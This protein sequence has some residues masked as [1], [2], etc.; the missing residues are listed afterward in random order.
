MLEKKCPPHRNL[1]TPTD[2]ECHSHESD[3]QQG[4]HNFHCQLLHCPHALRG[5]AR[6]PNESTFPP[7]NIMERIVST[8]DGNTVE[9]IL[10]KLDVLLPKK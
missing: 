6:Y 10:S 2:T 9:R 5:I 8:L 1:F 7:R 3:A 4:F